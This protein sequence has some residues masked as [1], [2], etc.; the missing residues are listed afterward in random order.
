[1]SKGGYSKK[2]TTHTIKKELGCETSRAF[3]GPAAK[4]QSTT[5]P[6]AIKVAGAE[7]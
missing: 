2:K 4:R 1:M 3:N 7:Q 6:A 5:S